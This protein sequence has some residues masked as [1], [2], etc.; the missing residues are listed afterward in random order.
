MRSTVDDAAVH[1]GPP[2]T[3]AP[4]LTRRRLPRL[5]LQ[6]PNYRQVCTGSTNH[7]EAIKVLFDPAK[8]SYAELAE[9]HFRM[10]DPSAFAL[11][12]HALAPLFLLTHHSRA[13]VQPRSTARA[14]TRGRSTA[15]P[16]SRRRTPRPR[17]PRRSATRC[18]RSTTR[19]RR[20]RRPSSRLAS[21][22]TPRTVRRVLSPLCRRVSTDHVLRF[23]DHQE[24]ASHPLALSAAADPP[25][26]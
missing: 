22:G 9:F 20:L 25:R 1:V 3:H 6:N 8:I 7:A 15:R 2:P 14:R 26:A 21:G 11:P 19:T 5:L 13:R 4:T 23:T 17:S 18:R 10:H 16:S 12:S 24:C